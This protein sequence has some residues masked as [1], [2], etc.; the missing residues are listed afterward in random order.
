MADQ[1]VGQHATASVINAIRSAVLRPAD[2]GYVRPLYVYAVIAVAVV[3]V[4]MYFHRY[5]GAWPNQLFVNTVTL[6]IA[7]AIVLL[8]G[9]LLVAAILVPAMIAIVVQAAAFKRQTMD[10]IVH[11]YDIFFYLFSWSTVTFLWEHYRGPLFM[12]IMALAAAVFATML[13][14]RYDPTRVPRR[15]AGVAF[16]LFAVLT[17]YA[18]DIKGE[19]RHTQFYWEDLVISSFYSSWAETAETLWRG[20]LIEA[21][22]H[23]NGPA[24]AV[25]GTCETTGKPPHI[26]LIH[27]ESVVPPSVVPGVTYDNR[28]DPFFRSS[29]GKMHKMR[30]ETYGG[31]SWLTEF[32]ILAGV[33]T[34]SFGGM[35]PFV[36]ALMA[37]KVRDTMPE[38][39]ARCGYRNVVFYPMLKNFVSNGKFYNAVGMP[40]IF[41]MKDQGAKSSAERDKFYYGNALNL[42]EQHFK[43][44]SQP[45]FTF[46]ITV[47]THQPYTFKYAPDENVPGGGPGTN[48]EMDEFLRRTWLAKMDYEWMR[49]ELE[50]RFPD[51]RFLIV[52]YGDH[53]PIATR[54]YFGSS[55]RAAEDVQL[56]KDSAAFITY[57][58]T[59]GI[60]YD[61]PPLPDVDVLDVPYLG[62]LLLEQARLP[63]S[64]S[65]VERRRL[66]TACGGR[67]YGCTRQGEIL[68][69]HRRLIDSGLI[70]AK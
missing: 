24:F 3:S 40:E 69:F 39:L 42:M 34:Y 18:A 52:Q 33:S 12:L 70:D 7:S 50:R 13:A 62:G 23:A 1:S 10:M 28:L 26:L 17:P 66:R 35:R 38:A 36:Q 53:H 55:A 37:G 22:A 47:A 21:A 45:L 65:Y 11:A 67:Y 54:S 14:Y 30:V 56:P 59:E 49:S 61:P 31:A 32:S 8:T 27:Q 60:N 63:L 51:E 43:A 19:R 58:S 20:T 5:E 6:M 4:G 16:A 46:L 64:D 29:D 68:S 48:P 15:Y 25:P 2:A 44:S 57:Y 41:D 9:R